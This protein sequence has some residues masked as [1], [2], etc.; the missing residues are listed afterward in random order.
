MRKID[1][2]IP[3]TVLIST[4]H[5]WMSIS[6]QDQAHIKVTILLFIYFF[7]SCDTMNRKHLVYV[8]PGF[9]PL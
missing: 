5:S 2:S 6:E 8:L 7:S 4:G 3:R 9:Y 1:L